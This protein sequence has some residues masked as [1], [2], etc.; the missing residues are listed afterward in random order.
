MVGDRAFI[1]QQLTPQRSQIL[2]QFLAQQKQP[3]GITPAAGVADLAS[4]LVDAF[5]Q[6]KL[7]QGEQAK[8]AA[9][10]SELANIL[11]SQTVEGAVPSGQIGPGAPVQQAPTLQ[12]ITQGLLGSQDPRL[13]QLGAQQQ[14]QSLQGQQELQGTI[15]AEQRAEQTQ[16]RKEERAAGRVAPSGFTLGPGQQRFNAQGNLIAGTAP[17]GVTLSKGEEAIDKAFAPD[18]VK[19]KT[20]GPA[21]T[22]KLLSQ[23]EAAASDLTGGKN[24]TG[25]LIG[26]TPD[27]LLNL[28][29]PQ[30]VKTREKVEEVAQR[31]LREILGGQFAQKEGEQL[32]KRAFN[33]GLDEATNLRR[34]Q[35][36]I[37]QMKIAFE[38]KAAAVNYFESVGTLK[39]FTGKVP[40]LADFNAALDSIESP[41]GQISAPQNAS[42]LL[43]AEPAIGDVN[44]MSEEELDAIIAG[45]R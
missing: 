7:L 42:P 9:S 33:P 10:G 18:F 3:T 27:F 35:A 14:L 16:I 5:T 20:G 23:L 8:E 36:L 13:Q 44:A 24:I 30:A 31:N 17:P 26:A 1:E 6:R 43:Q 22:I 41:A 2:A 12:G 37:Q 11:G 15:G 29:N 28:I 39:G 21:D 38:Q 34:V 25:P 19:F 32:I 4:N 40:T 45:G